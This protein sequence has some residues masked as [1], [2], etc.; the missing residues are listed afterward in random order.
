M[1]NVYVYHVLS[2]GLIWYRSKFQEKVKKEE[3]ILLTINEWK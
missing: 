3:K 1:W 2:I